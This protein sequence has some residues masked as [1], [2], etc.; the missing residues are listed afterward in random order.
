MI[1]KSFT[2][3]LF[4][5]VNSFKGGTK[6]SPCNIIVYRSGVIYG[7][8]I[9]L[10]APTSFGIRTSS[11]SF[12]TIFVCGS[13]QRAGS[14]ILALHDASDVFLEIGKLTKYSGV[15][16]IPEIS[17]GLF[18]LSWFLLRLLYF[19]FVII[20]STTYVLSHFEFQLA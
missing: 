15:Q 8:S 10:L 14:V 11:S 4:H 1:Q 9:F 12:D 5:Q 16:V 2:R 7:E 17:F 20:K 6:V 3:C 19:P 13:L 18:A